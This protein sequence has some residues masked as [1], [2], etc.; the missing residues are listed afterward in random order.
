[1]NPQAGDPG[2]VR[3]RGAVCTHPRKGDE[4]TIR[5]WVRDWGPEDRAICHPIGYE[6][7]AEAAEVVAI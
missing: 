6:R 3:G 2:A 4:H 5:R 1:M 7:A